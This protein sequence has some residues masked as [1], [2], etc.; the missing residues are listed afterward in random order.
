VGTMNLQPISDG[1]PFRTQGCEIWSFDGVNWTQVVGDKSN[2]EINGGFGDKKNIGA[3]SMIE[4]PLGS[5]MLWVGTWNMDFNDYNDFKG[6][7]IWK[8]Q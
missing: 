1:I 7:E 2:S 3:R 4:Y 8:R 5:G 6:F